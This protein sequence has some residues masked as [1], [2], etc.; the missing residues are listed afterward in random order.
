M[1]SLQSKI[2][3]GRR[4]DSSGP[5]FTRMA[6]NPVCLCLM[7]AAVVF[8]LYSPA[9]RFGFSRYDD[10]KYFTQNQHVQAGLGWD[11]L[12][13]AFRSVVVSNWHPLTM[14]SFMLD[15]TLAGT[16]DPSV[17]H[18]T[19]I[20][21]HAINSVLLFL[22][23][24][25]LTGARW[26]SLF[27]AGLFA[28]HPL[29]VESVAWIAE[30]KNVLSTCFWLLTIFAYARFVRQSKVNN[31]VSGLR[32]PASGYYW[33]ALLLF[34]LGLMSKPMLVTLPFVLLLL[35]DWPWGRWRMTSIREWRVRLPGLAWEKS[36]FFILSGLSCAVTL[37]VQQQG[38]AMRFL[39]GLSL[40]GR[41]ENAFVSYVRYLGKTCWPVNLAIHY[42]HPGYWPPVAA[43][44]AATFILAASFVV[45]RSGKKYRYLGTGWFWFLGTLIPVI[46]VIQVGGQSMADR[47]A[48]VPLI[49]IFIMASW[50]AFEILQGLKFPRM[51]M[52]A[53]A[54][55]ILVA[56][57]C[58]SRKQL[59]YWQNDETLFRHALAVTKNNVVARIMLGD[60][61]AHAEKLDEAIKNYREALAI[62]PNDTFAANVRC[63][64][65]TALDRAGQFAEAEKEYREALRIDPN[66]FLAHYDMGVHFVLLGRR[67]EAIEQFTIAGRLKPEM[68]EPRQKLRALGVNLR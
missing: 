6:A 66:F 34:A 42:P 14:L 26:R 30:R 1:E 2:S 28:L 41:I 32:L 36:P 38:A 45:I 10:L 16:L 19:N 57:A 48:Y 27:V 47:Y 4:R 63:K 3:R 25:Y 50:G 51:A 59:N 43:L 21:L 68:P 56:G 49:G 29:N 54:G 18:F 37:M 12:L 7:L 40:G 31:Q 22:L 8:W 5:A 67:E 23:L 17:P 39:D 53:A 24:Q 13:W 62:V 55:V 15:A 52:Y 65:G 33:L 58:Q 11:G 46:G 60:E 20:L 64:L 35:D 61:L 9:I 44:A